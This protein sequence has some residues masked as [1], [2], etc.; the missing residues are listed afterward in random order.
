MRHTLSFTKCASHLNM[1]FLKCS[2]WLLNVSCISSIL[3]L[4]RDFGERF[5][6]LFTKRFSAILSV[7]HVLFQ[8]FSAVW[9]TASWITGPWTEWMGT[10]CVTRL[11]TS[12]HWETSQKTQT[13]DMWFWYCLMVSDENEIILRQK[14]PHI[15]R[16]VEIKKNL[17]SL[18][19]ALQRKLSNKH[20]RND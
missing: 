17:I 3:S 4:K 18:T 9:N 19:P 14:F 15:L 7:G 12:C 11:M 2:L 16:R 1:P 8:R 10:G 20:V 5:C 6:P 13:S